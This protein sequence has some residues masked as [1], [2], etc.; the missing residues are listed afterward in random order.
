MLRTAWAARGSHLTD[1]T[2]CVAGTRTNHG[3]V[4]CYYRSLKPE[5][6]MSV[7]TLKQAVN[8][9]NACLSEL[10]TAEEGG[11]LEGMWAE[12]NAV[13]KVEECDIYSYIPDLED[14]PFSQGSL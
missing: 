6:F 4:R 2:P 1:G 14:D 12:V 13:I 10:T 7:P 3:H 9:V 11:F 8:D 5:S